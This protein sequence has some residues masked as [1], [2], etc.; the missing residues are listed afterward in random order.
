MPKA[1]PDEFRRDVIAVARK[2]DRPA[3][4]A[5]HG[6]VSSRSRRAPPSPIRSVLRIASADGLV[7]G[8]PALIETASWD[9]QHADI[10]PG[11]T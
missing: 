10:R 6:P 11:R 3:D 4:A 9:Q 1:F 5:A 8:V 2:N 7:G